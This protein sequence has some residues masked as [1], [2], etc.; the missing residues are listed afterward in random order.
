[1]FSPAR[2]RGFAPAE[3]ALTFRIAA[4]D[5]DPLFLPELV[6]HLG[7]RRRGRGSSDAAVGRSTTGAAWPG[8]GRPGHRHRLQPPGELHL[9]G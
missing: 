1:M 7:T 6:A 2:A 9:A 8:A 4:S 5:P 3:T